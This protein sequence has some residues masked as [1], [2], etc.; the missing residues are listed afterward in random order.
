MSKNN[1]DINKPTCG[2]GESGAPD[3]QI[4]DVHAHLLR[5][6]NNSANGSQGTPLVFVLFFCGVILWAGIALTKKEDHST[7]DIQWANTE[8]VQGTTG[9]PNGTATTGPA[10]ATNNGKKLYNTPGAC[11][12]CHQANGQGLEA[13]NFPPLASSEWVTGA[14]DILIKIVLHGLQGP[15]KVNGKDYG[16]VPMVPTIW[17]TWSDED[18]ASVLTYIRSEWGNQAPEVTAASVKKIRD[19][20]GERGPWT[21]EELQAK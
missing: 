2:S 8:V 12:T 17:K 4:L 10:T 5:T 9:A 1:L 3:D 11:V 13:A 7:Y 15:I 16:A 21:V 14:E 19:E 18:I 20:L 6:K